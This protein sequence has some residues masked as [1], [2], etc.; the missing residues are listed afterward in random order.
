MHKRFVNSTL[1][2]P[3]LFLV[4]LCLISFQVAADPVLDDNPSE[5]YYRIPMQLMILSQAETPTET[6]T[7][8]PPTETPTEIPAPPTESP[9]VTPVP[10]TESPTPAPPT[11]V[12]TE[13]PT[14]TPVP[15]TESPTPAPPTEVPTESPTATP[16][17]AEPL[18][19]ILG[20]ASGN[21]SDEIVVP[22]TV[23]NAENVDAFGFQITQSVDL[24]DFEAVDSAGT[25]TEDF[26]RIIASELDDPAGAIQIAAIG[27]T[28]SITADE[29]VLLKLRF[30]ATAAG[31]TTL[32][33]EEVLDDLADAGIT[34]NTVTISEVEATPTPTVTPET[35]VETPTPTALPTDTPT[36]APTPTPDNFQNPFQ[37]IA[38][39]DGYGGI[40]D[41]GDV[42][43]FFDLNGDGMLEAWTSHNLPFFSGEDVYRD[44]EL[45]VEEPGTENAEITA[46]LAATGDGRIFSGRVRSLR[47]ANYIET[48]FVGGLGLDFESLNVLRDVE[49]TDNA[50]GYFAL[51]NNGT[52]FSVEGKGRNKTTHLI[53]GV[54]TNPDENPTVD[55]EVIPGNANPGNPSGYIL[56]SFG[57]IHSIGNAPQLSGN[58]ITDVPLFKDME[59]YIDDEGEL[60]GAILVDGFGKFFKATRSGAAPEELNIALPEL[61]FG[62]NFAMADFEIQVDK[63]TIPGR[64]EA[65]LDIFNRRGVFA[66]TN[67]GSIHTSGAADFFLEEDRS[68]VDET[69]DGNLFINPGISFNIARDL[70]VYFFM[71]NQ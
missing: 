38:L 34:S 52:V 14:V 28:S 59:L 11:E 2:G 5:H 63:L 7:V 46:Y 45:Y 61:L 51:L 48:D 67:I 44:L 31:E 54:I 32:N 35:P 1:G 56:D 13:S 50:N 17:P 53:N 15:P 62:T 21:V 8:V 36:P 57:R 66:M 40:H 71:E 39:L 6:P 41:L 37:G 24:L 64:D 43:G 55:L 58:P 69:A 22:I 9:T 49:F 16:V 20:D 60:L 65:L 70:E 47:N 4:F 25:L 26:F 29:G 33:F 42:V 68:N 10:P 23:Q 3:I 18:E 30:T 19:L 27:G 12:P